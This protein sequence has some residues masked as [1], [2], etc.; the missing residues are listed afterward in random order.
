VSF[1]SSECRINLNV[2]STVISIDFAICFAVIEQSNHP[3]TLRL[4]KL[5]P[6]HF[7]GYDE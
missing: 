1:I 4:D 3:C 2:Q 5:Q 6:K 7:V